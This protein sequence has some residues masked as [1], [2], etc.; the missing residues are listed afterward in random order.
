VTAADRG[1][2]CGGVQDTDARDRRQQPS[3]LV[4]AG[5][6]GELIIERRD[7]TV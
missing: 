1:R 3:R 7:T 6:C 5:S 2:Q 4:A